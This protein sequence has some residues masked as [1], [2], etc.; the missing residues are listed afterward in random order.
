MATEFSSQRTLIGL[1]VSAAAVAAGTISIYGLREVMPVA[2]AGLVYLLPVLLASIRW[3][4]WLGV[5]AAIASAAAFNWFHLPPS[6]KWTIADEQNWVALGAFLVVAV[7]TSGLADASRGRAEEAERGRREADLLTEMAQAL[8]G[9]SN[10]EDSLPLVGERIARAF[11]LPSVEVTAGWRDS[12]ASGR[13]LPILVGGNRAGTVVI[14]KDTSAGVIQAIEQRVIPGLET[15]L[16]AA[17]QREELQAQVIETRALRRSDVVKTALLR[18]VSHD[19]RSPLTA[20]MAAA[21]GLASRTRDDAASSELVSVITT[22][23]ER[24]TRLVNNLLDLSR[25]QSGEAEPRIELCTAEELIGTTLDSI[26]VPT[27]AL[28]VELEPD[29]PSVAVD[30]AQV[31]RALANVIENS[32]RYS[33]DAPVVVRGHAIGKQVV[34]E[35]SDCG[36]GVSD[37]ERERIFEPFYR[38]AGDRTVGSGLG[39][40]IARGFAQANGGDLRL[41]QGRDRGTRFAFHFPAVQEPTVTVS[42]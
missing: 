24:L 7:V 22:E 3:G 37:S 15:L 23:S 9:R 35:V 17:R 8:L 16:T 27:A 30:A 10:F 11:D 42:A 5:A 6:G 41:R 28:D 4:L 13:S 39:L 32:L 20:I 26:D 40:A 14:P 29:L 34:I 25:L 2:G 36:P 21:G 19:L 18:S 1:T 31:E 12:G 38:G 33:G